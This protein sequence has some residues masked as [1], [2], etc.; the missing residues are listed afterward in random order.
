MSTRYTIKRRDCTGE[1]LAVV[2]AASPEDA[3]YKFA[4]S[5]KYDGMTRATGDAGKTGCFRGTESR[6]GA[7][8]CGEPFHVGIA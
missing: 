5:R 2:E 4:R 7:L 8:H 3:A 1:L 6:G